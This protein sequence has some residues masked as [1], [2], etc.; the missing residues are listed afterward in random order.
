MSATRFS[1]QGLFVIS[2]CVSLLILLFLPLRPWL[3]RVAGSQWICALWLA[4]LVRLLLPGPVE[5]G[6]GL[7]NAWQRGGKEPAGVFWT[8]KFG[9]ARKPEPE[10]T[11]TEVP[12][13]PAAGVAAPGPRHDVDIP[14]T[15]W[16]SGLAAA[17]AILAWRWV[18]VRRLAAHTRPA[19]DERL[20]AI[21]ASIPAQWRRKVELRMTEAVNVPTLAGVIRPQI[22]MPRGW[23]ARLSDPELRSILLHELGHMRRHDLAVQWLF[24]FARCVHWFNPLVWLAA[25]AARLDREMAC[26]AW[27][28][29]H[30]GADDCAGYGSALLR[31]AVLF[32]GALHAPAAT[33]A[34]VSGR[35]NLEARII[36]IGAFRPAR[37]WPGLLGVTLMIAALAVATTSRRISAQTS[38]PPAVSPAPTP[39]ASPGPPALGP[40]IE[41]DAKYV[42]IEEP[43]W[44]QMSAKYAFFRDVTSDIGNPGTGRNADDWLDGGTRPDPSSEAALAALGTGKWMFKDGAWRTQSPIRLSA[45]L[46]D[47]QRRSISK[48]FGQ[49]QGVDVIAGPRV[50]FHPGSRCVA[51]MVREYRFPARFEPDK[52][53]P[54][55]WSP[56][57]F[58]TQDI[59]VRLETRTTTLE[60]AGRN[61]VIDLHLIPEVT[62]FLGFLARQDGAAAVKPDPAGHSLDPGWRP[63]FSTSRGD[64]DR[65]VAPGETVLLEGVSLGRQAMQDFAGPSKEPASPNSI[66]PRVLLVFVTA[67]LLG[68]NGLPVHDI[69]PAS[70]LPSATPGVDLPP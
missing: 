62:D 5:T 2:G 65:K 3:R 29:S 16:L 56:A 39:A 21:Y 45:I 47:G 19:T 34:M 49:R 40:I 42:E 31:T 66:R 23:P 48:L 51:E 60:G 8:V 7:I 24:E 36:G 22:W 58:D 35:K 53:S 43:V 10:H 4:L 44:K 63:I 1:S 70:P 59:G 69:S 11:A 28:L 9:G 6:C 20:L 67:S 27:V 61:T 26:D 50:T 32:S 25:R 18:Q 52:H 64:V 30:N 14:L 68:A 38:T 17:L 33:V 55:G 54:S 13:A 12:A 46:S 41:I 15:I 57:N 37:S